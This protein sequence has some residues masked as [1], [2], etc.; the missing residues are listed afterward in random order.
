MLVTKQKIPSRLQSCSTLLKEGFDTNLV[1]LLVCLSRQEAGAEVALVLG[2]CNKSSVGKHVITPLARTKRGCKRCSAGKL[3]LMGWI[4]SRV[5]SEQLDQLKVL[6]QQRERHEVLP[7]SGSSNQAVM[8]SKLS[9]VSSVSLPN[10]C[11]VSGCSWFQVIARDGDRESIAA[12]DVDAE[13]RQ[14]LLTA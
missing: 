10:P 12:H 6:N 2:S 7:V 9:Q 14:T 11:D 5:L 13:C 4:S 1:I 8:A 3:M